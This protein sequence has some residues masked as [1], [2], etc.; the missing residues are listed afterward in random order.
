MLAGV[1]SLQRAK[2]IGKNTRR[3]RGKIQGG[4]HA[5]NGRPVSQRTAVFCTG[6]ACCIGCI[7]AYIEGQVHRRIPKSKCV[8]ER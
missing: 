7:N 5:G 6:C 1:L 3:Y 4:T 2:A 8:V